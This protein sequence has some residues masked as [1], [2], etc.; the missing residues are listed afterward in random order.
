MISTDWISETVQ[1]LAPLATAKEAAAVLRM[2]QRQLRRLI[3]ADRIPA[4]RGRESG[5][6]RVLVPR[7]SIEKYL[8]SLVVSP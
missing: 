2:S 6:S 3:I 7:A 4:I 8:R 5:S 1:T